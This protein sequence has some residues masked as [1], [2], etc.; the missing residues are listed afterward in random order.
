MSAIELSGQ[1]TF[2]YLT[3]GTASSTQLVYLFLYAGGIPLGDLELMRRLFSA[4]AVGKTEGHPAAF[5]ADILSLKPI[6]SRRI[7][8]R[9]GTPSSLKAIEKSRE[10]TGPHAPDLSSQALVISM[11]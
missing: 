10:V 4:I 6:T 7:S 11:R 2:S 9:G 8:G 5:G 1:D 3:G